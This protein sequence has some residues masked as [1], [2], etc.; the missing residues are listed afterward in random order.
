LLYRGG[1][2]RG[3]GSGRFSIDTRSGSRRLHQRPQGGTRGDSLAFE[4]E[5]GRI[6]GRQRRAPRVERGT[7]IRQRGISLHGRGAGNEQGGTAI[8]QRGAANR[9]RGT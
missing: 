5:P 7:A 9:Q 2:G 6:R 3:D 4:G 8:D 1:Y